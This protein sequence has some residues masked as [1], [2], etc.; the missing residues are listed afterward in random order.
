MS[1]FAKSLDVNKSKQISSSLW[2]YTLSLRFEAKVSEEQLT[3][4]RNL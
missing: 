4:E 1:C 3:S 2:D